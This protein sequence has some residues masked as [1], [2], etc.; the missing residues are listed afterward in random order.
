MPTTDPIHKIPTSALVPNPDSDAAER[1]IQWGSYPTEN[2]EIRCFANSYSLPVYDES[3]ATGTITVIRRPGFNGPINVT[4]VPY[5][6]KYVPAGGSDAGY[7]VRNSTTGR[8]YGF[9]GVGTPFY[10]GPTRYLPV[11][12]AYIFRDP[13]GV[14]QDYRTS[15]AN[16]RGATGSGYIPHPITKAELDAG[17]IEHW[18]PIYISNAMKSAEGYAISPAGNFEQNTNSEPVANYNEDFAVPMGTRIGLDPA[19]YTDSFI[20]AW[21]LAKYPTNATLRLYAQ[22][23]A[24]AMRDYGIFTQASGP[25]WGV[26]FDKVA[27]VPSEL[28]AGLIN[29]AAPHVL[30]FHPPTST[31]ADGTRTT[32][33]GWAVSIAYDDPPDP[34]P[35]PDPP[36]TADLVATVTFDLPLAVGVPW[37]ATGNITVLGTDALDVTLSLNLLSS[38]LGTD[39][40]ISGD[41]GTILNL[42]DTGVSL[43][44]LDVDT[45][46]DFA[47]TGSS[48]VDLD[49]ISV[50][51]LLFTSSN[52]DPEYPT[53][54]TEIIPTEYDMPTI[55][56]RLNGGIRNIVASMIAAGSNV[57]TSYNDTTK[58]LT[59]SA[60]GGGGGGGLTT[61]DVQDAV[62]AL[63]VGSNGITTSYNDAS[64]TLT[65]S[66]SGYMPSSYLDTSTSLGTS[67]TKVPSQKAVKTY[68]DNS[69]AAI[70]GGGGGSSGGFGPNTVAAANAPAAVR[71]AVVAAGGTVCDGTADQ[72]EINTALTTYDSVLLTEGTF[73]ISSAI[74]VPRGTALQGSGVEATTI[75]FANSITSRGIYLNNVDHVTLSDFSIDGNNY[76]SSVI[77][78][79]SVASSNSGFPSHQTQETCHVFQRLQIHDV[80]GHGVSLTGTYNRDTKIHAI[81]VH[82]AGASGFYLNCPDGKMS[83]CVAGSPGAWGF[84]VDGAAN[85]HLDNC[86]AWYCP[87]DGFGIGINNATG[88]ITLTACEAQ[89]CTRA[90]FRGVKGNAVTFTGCIADSNS[91]NNSGTYSGFEIALSSPTSAS[92]AY[93]TGGWTLTGCVA[94]DKNE[95][96]RGY[97]QKYG[98]RFG[99]GIRRLVLVGCNT[100]D[101]DNHHNVTD[102]ISFNTAGDATN[103]TNVVLSNNH[104]VLLKSF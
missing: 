74:T 100:G 56:D 20:A 76:G 97:N 24:T 19:Y 37:S 7:M 6:S 95:G 21:A 25:N 27:S 31:L 45:T 54:S 3:L 13:N 75:A 71:A 63:I 39:V 5:T 78:I 68:V 89:D 101:A 22:T 103:S 1:I 48:V 62:A 83:Q 34:D 8:H 26:I 104:G 41:L 86:K 92:G 4:T 51:G 99:S 91:L 15:T 102:G 33:A 23:V 60:T 69:I 66:V 14:E 47:I 70:P 88:R 42:D 40:D 84:L 55:L 46:Y 67:D 73:T 90:G 2:A 52:A 35:D 43:G 80:T 30:T 72:T 10:L 65:I 58:V 85:W 49:D 57:T 93:V 98:F 82:N 64:N 94:Y 53:D 18:V 12:A 44:T 9:W 17:L 36:A 11:G 29:P 81:D 50:F 77:G 38:N 32:L 28:M 87:Q 96:A 61:E 59:I 79:E 16:M